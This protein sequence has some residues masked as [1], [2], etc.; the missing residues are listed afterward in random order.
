VA[1]GVVAEATVLGPACE[2]A[3]SLLQHGCDPVLTGPH[4]NRYPMRMTP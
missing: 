1:A 2:G 3:A 4:P